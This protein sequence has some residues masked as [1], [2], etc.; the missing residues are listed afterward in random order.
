MQ[1]FAIGCHPSSTTSSMV[2]SLLVIMGLEIENPSNRENM[3]QWPNPG[4]EEIC[5]KRPISYEE[6][7]NGLELI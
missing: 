4:S 1:V 7:I 5:V 6:E 2:M 3:E